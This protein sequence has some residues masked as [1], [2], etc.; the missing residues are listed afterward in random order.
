MSG[1]FFTK[2]Q[3]SPENWW[4]VD[5]NKE[6][7]SSVYGHNDPTWIWEHTIPDPVPPPITQF[8]GVDFVVR[9]LGTNNTGFKGAFTPT[10]EKVL[11]SV[12]AQSPGKVL[13][14]FSGRSTLGDERVD[15]DRP[16]ATYRGKVED[17]VTEDHRMWEWVVLDPPYQIERAAEKMDYT[18]SVSLAA[19]VQLRHKVLDYL[20]SHTNNVLW[21]DYMTPLPQGFT[22]KQV[23]MFLPGGYHPVVCLNWLQNNINVQEGETL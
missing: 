21:L 6:Y 20:R 15:L 8:K 10:V 16:E 3:L 19:D 11:N 14:L 5:A 18:G 7:I 22:R 2:G 12:I 17:F 1:E 13:N 4:M 9:G 23:W